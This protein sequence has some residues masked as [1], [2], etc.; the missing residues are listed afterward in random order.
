MWNIT[1]EGSKEV[2]VRHNN[3]IVARFKY[4]SPKASA[5]HFVKFLKANCS[6]EEYFAKRKL[7]IPPLYILHQKG[8]VSYNEQRA[9]KEAIAGA[10][11]VWA[12]YD[13]LSF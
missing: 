7:G 5:K 8:Y 4:A 12:M 6:P 3:E 1:I 13:R 9:A 11:K 10:K 2:Y